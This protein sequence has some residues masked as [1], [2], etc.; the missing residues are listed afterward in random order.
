MHSEPCFEFLL[1]NK[2]KFLNKQIE[3]IRSQ[4]EFSFQKP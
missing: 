1:Y 3:D 2:H 4:L